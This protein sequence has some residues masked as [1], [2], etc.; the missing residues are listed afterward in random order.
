MKDLI[1][2]ITIFRRF[3]ISSSINRLTSLE[4]HINKVNPYIHIAAALNFDLKYIAVD[5]TFMSVHNCPSVLLTF[6]PKS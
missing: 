4:K 5:I 2:A 3:S 6:I 1:F